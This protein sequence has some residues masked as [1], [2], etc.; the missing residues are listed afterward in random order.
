MVEFRIAREKRGQRMSESSQRI[1]K[2]MNR[3]AW[4]AIYIYLSGVVIAMALL[5]TGLHLVLT[6]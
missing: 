6:R 5:L 4:T 3:W 1:S 2:M